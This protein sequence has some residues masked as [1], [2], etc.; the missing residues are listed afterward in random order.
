MSDNKWLVAGLGNPGNSYENN[1][2]NVGFMLVDKL[3]EKLS[4]SL[5]KKKFDGVFGKGKFKGNEIFLLKPFSYMNRSGGPVR[6]LSQ[7]F[8]VNVSRIILVYDDLDLPPGKIRIRTK[9]GSGGHNGI[10]S[11]IENFGTTEIGRIKVGIGRPEHREQVISYVLHDFDKEELKIIEK[12]IEKAAEAI[13]EII[14]NGFT[15]C[16]NNFNK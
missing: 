11:V 4:I 1:R 14:V 16:M 9:G 6:G 15:A 5:D 10:K 13:E 12:G 3:S 7:Y 8:N 2:H